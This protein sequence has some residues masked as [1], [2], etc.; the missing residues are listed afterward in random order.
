MN[1]RTLRSD[2]RRRWRRTVLRLQGRLDGEA[3]DRVLPWAFALATFVVFVALD[4]AALRSLEGGSGLGPWLQAVWRREHGGVGSPLG[5]VDPAR[6]AW[7]L[8]AEPVLWLGRFAPPTAVF[9]IVQAAAIALGIVPLWRL[10]RDEA[11]LR[12]GASSVAV[13]A[14]VLAPTLHRTNL[15]VFH[16]E[17]IALPLLLWAYLFARRDHWKRYGVMV[18]R[19]SVV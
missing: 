17:A 16:P 13:A 10:A 18:D 8:I 11:R 1:D 5:G 2:V 4:A 3:A 6:G 7:S 12:V 15:A 19:K 9:A 14:Y